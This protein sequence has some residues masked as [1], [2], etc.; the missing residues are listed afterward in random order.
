MFITIYEP[1]TAPIRGLASAKIASMIPPGSGFFSMIQNMRWGDNGV[2]TTKSGASLLTTNLSAIFAPNTGKPR[3]C[4]TLPVGTDLSYAFASFKR[5]IDGETA[6][7]YANDMATWT[8]LT[9]A[10]GTH[11]DTRFSNHNDYETTFQI[12]Y[13]RYTQKHYIVMQNGYDYPRVAVY[14]TAGSAAIH[15]PINPPTRSNNW[16]AMLTW[17]SYFKVRDYTNVSYSGTPTNYSIDNTTTTTLGINAIRLNHTAATPSGA[18]TITISAANNFLTG[19][20]SVL[21]AADSRQLILVI[22]PFN[23][24]AGVSHFLQNFKIS[25]KGTGATI[26][27]LVDPTNTSRQAT[28]VP[29]DLSSRTYVV[30]CAL[31]DVAALDADSITQVIIEPASNATA[32]SAYQLDI[33][34]IAASGNVPGNVSYA[35]TY[36]NHDSRAESYEQVLATRT[37]RIQANG[38]KDLT[39]LRMPNSELLYYQTWVNFQNT[40]DAECAKGVDFVRVYRKQLSSDPNVSE[41]DFTLCGE[42]HMSQYVSGAWQFTQSTSALQLRATPDN[43]APEDRTLWLTSP[44]AFQQPIPIARCMAQA[45]NRLVCGARVSQAVDSFPRLAAS[46]V[47]MPFRFSSLSFDEN[48]LA[49]P[50]EQEVTG[51]NLQGFAVAAGSG[52]GTNVV[53]VFTDQAVWV[54]NLMAVGTPTL[55]SREM[56]V[57][58][59]SPFTIVERHGRVYFMDS[60]RQVRLIASDSYVQA[61]TDSMPGAVGEMPI[62]LSRGL[63]DDL[64]RAIPN[65]RVRAARAL[66]FNDRFY[67]FYS[68]PDNGL[69]GDLGDS[70]NSQCLVFSEHANAW[71]S[72][73]TFDSM[74]IECPI[75]RRTTATSYGSTTLPKMFAISLDD[76]VYQ[77]EVPGVKL[78]FLTD[79]IP[80]EIKTGDLHQ[81]MWSGMH[82][83]GLGLLA[84]DQNSRTLTGTVTYKPTSLS[85]SFTLSLDSTNPYQ[86][87]IQRTQSAAANGIAASVDFAGSI[88]GE[89][90]I[91][92]LKME[93]EPREMLAP[94]AG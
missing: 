63:V 60:D 38:A 6:V 20:E 93:V 25:V 54:L 28:V 71:E 52:F 91:Y 22:R 82:V 89:N 42:A 53:I 34:T 46:G 51:E 94:N 30:A 85:S 12:V 7:Y 37:E 79:P 56:S 17:A 65:D 40:T 32:P 15:E 35:I 50:F 86:W 5:S 70:Y 68:R 8:E 59:D 92:A 84:D 45:G 75:S 2:L 31:D 23:G 9:A 24:D 10:T 61:P 29:V 14:N 41:Q 81:S 55:L 57:G 3:G 11:N 77:L 67:L 48:N 80:V 64:L 33:L 74:Q 58:T 62:A 49:A 69:P 73:D 43:L 76:N 88:K 26:Y 87:S 39:G 18:T 36:L 16:G 83:K 47:S 72:R 13:D 66:W 1:Q 27:P 4:V 19:A 90:R 21:K 78:D 44:G